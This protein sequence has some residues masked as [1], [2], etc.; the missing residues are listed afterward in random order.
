MPYHQKYK[1]DSKVCE[2]DSVRENE[3]QLEVHSQEEFWIAGIRK[4]GIALR[5]KSDLSNEKEYLIG[6]NY[7]GRKWRIF[8]KVTKISPTN[9]FTRQSYA[10]LDNQK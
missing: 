6:R 9:N 10:Q 7:V 8:W 1:S 4:T 3:K 5:M 2:V